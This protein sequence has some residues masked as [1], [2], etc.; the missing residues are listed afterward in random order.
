M[1][2]HLFSRAT[3]PV[4]HVHALDLQS[5][6]AVEVSFFVAREDNKLLG[7]GALRDLG[8]SRA[9]IKSMHTASIARGRGVGRRMLL[10]IISTARDRSITWLGLETGSMIEFGPARNLYESVGFVECEPFDRY[11][12]NTYSTCMSMRLDTVTP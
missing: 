7:V 10:H 11:I 3:S 4:E 2:P 8:D 5:L 6:T 9:E 1:K 12:R